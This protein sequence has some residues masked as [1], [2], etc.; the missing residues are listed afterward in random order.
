MTTGLE[1]VLVGIDVSK[2]E[3]VIARND[4]DQIEI[5]SNNLTSIRRWLKSLPARAKVALEATGI[6]HRQVA[7]LVHEAGHSLYLLDAY[8]LSH[9]RD[10]VGTRA[11]TD[12]ADARLILRYLTREL[13]ELK[14]WIPPHDAFY[15]VQSLMRRRAALVQTRVALSQSLQDIPELKQAA[16]QLDQH[17]RRI[18]Q[19]IAQRI[20]QA[21]TEAGWHSDAQRCDAIEGVGP[22]TAMALANTFHRGR[23]KNSDAFIAYLGM[24]VKVRDSGTQRGRRKLTKKGDPELRRLL[25]NAAMAARK[26]SAWKG[27]YESYLTQG[28]QPIQALVKLARKLARIAFA[29]MQNQTTYQLKKAA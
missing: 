19:M 16:R 22:L 18:E 2:A 26:T 15:R 1:S 17:I 24:D 20:K 3:L 5:L 6:Y 4:T 8:K 28:L 23:F 25:Y 7:R 21:L 11:K 14:P 27:L 9:Y 12:L 13:D 29:L 10:G